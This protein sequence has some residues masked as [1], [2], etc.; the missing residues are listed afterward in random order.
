VIVA[1]EP[2]CANASEL[3]ID[4]ALARS[5]VYRTLSLGFHETKGE[6]RE[7]LTSATARQGL[8]AA[9]DVVD[10]VS[11]D[12]EPILP[13]ALGLV[14]VLGAGTRDGAATYQHLFGHTAQGLVC[15]YETEYGLDALFQQPQALADIAGYYLAFGL[16]GESRAGHR[17]DHVGCECEFMDFLSRKEA[18]ML[19][20]SSDP[21]I[22]EQD[23]HRETLEQTRLAARKF[24]R[25]HLN[26]FGRAF[27]T[28]LVKEA[29]GGFFGALGVLLFSLLGSES[30]R[31]RIPAGSISLE[32]R[33]TA[34]ED[35]PTGCGTGQELIQIQ[36]RVPATEGH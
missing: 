24:M 2:I 17:V 14:D 22:A 15:P 20:L 23:D 5:V 28:R 8:T 32:L 10:S 19:E 1:H 3:A 34:P 33:S 16:R 36:R 30:A 21:Q 27:A 25:D 13:A 12:V 7:W 31:F 26:R 11:G 9:A 29:K 6:N 35:V 4:L 18:M